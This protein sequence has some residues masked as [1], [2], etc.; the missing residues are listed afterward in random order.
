MDKLMY[1]IGLIDQVTKPLRGI[2]REITSVTN[3]ARRGWTNIGTGAAGLWATGAAIQGV[4]GPANDLQ[5]ALGEVR[6]MGVSDAALKQLKNTALNFS[7]DFGK[8]AVDVVKSAY[9]IQSAISG[10]AGDELSTF[11]RAGGILAAA[12]KADSETIT[13]YMGTMYGIFQQSANEMGKGKWVE[14]LTGMTASA[15]QLFKTT[16]QGMADAFKGVGAN[17][18]DAGVGMAEQMAILGTLQATMSG[19]EAGTKYRSFIDNI[20]K[21]EKALGLKFT[22]AAGKHLPILEILDKIQKK[23]GDVGT[24]SASMELQKA[25]GTTEAVSMIKLLMQNTSG[26]AT[27]INTIGESSGME[28]A[29]KMARD[30]IDP[31]AQIEA[32][33]FAVRSAGMSGVLPALNGVAKAF[34]NGAKTVIRWTNL[35]PN[36]TKYVGY[37]VISVLSLAAAMAVWSIVAGGAGL[38]MS[39]LSL[40]MIAIKS[41]L[42]ILRGVMLALQVVQWLFNTA[43]LACPIT[44]IVLGIMALIAIVIAAIYYWDEI[45]AAI[46]DTAAF[47]WLMGVIDTLRTGWAAF[48]DMLGNLNPIKMLGSAIDWLIDKLNMIPGINIDKGTGA[49][50]QV[51]EEMDSINASINAYRGDPAGDVPV[52]GLGKQ[53]VNM[54][55]AASKPSNVRTYGDININT[56]TAMTPDQLDEW[57]LMATP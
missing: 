56:Q 26:L 34:T 45:K 38:V 18:T 49:I 16:G 9:N 6:S 20:G 21:A 8:S 14:N 22:N 30:M 39:G 40:V 5:N 50:T 24:V 29:E 7:V 42:L 23:F 27:S 1:T 52:G 13:S 2:S 33:L 51:P 43:L 36:L 19:G 44:W 47:Q 35:F 3:S 17:A 48:M 25:F 54:N 12:T 53:L 4:L 46:M 32:S 10:L 55:A 57:N 41:P 15:V 31:F 11:T 37:A 28:Q